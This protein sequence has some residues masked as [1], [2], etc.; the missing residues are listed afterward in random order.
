MDTRNPAVDLVL[1]SHAKLFGI[2][3]S[4]NAHKDFMKGDKNR[5]RVLKRQLEE[6]EKKSSPT[7]YNK[8]ALHNVNA[9]ALAEHTHFPPR[10]RESYR[11]LTK[12]N[13]FQTYKRHRNDLQLS[14][15]HNFTR[16]TNV[17][18]STEEL[19]LRVNDLTTNMRRRAKDPLPCTFLRGKHEL[20]NI[21]DWNDHQDILLS[22]F[23]H[24]VEFYQ[25]IKEFHE[26]T[27]D[28]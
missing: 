8:N 3:A 16:H 14:M 15:E 5:W 9:K 10:D 13:T 6:T 12:K 4:L 22:E 20:H 27:L 17:E 11:K 25:Q 24:S 1:I 7:K 18:I 28:L 23:L 19:K 21:A 26:L 2:R